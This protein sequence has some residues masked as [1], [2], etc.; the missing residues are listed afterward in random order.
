M[1]I[2]RA[3][4][5]LALLLA[6]GLGGW[7]IYG[8]FK[9][10]DSAS[11]VIYYTNPQNENEVPYSVTLGPARDPQSV[12]FYAATQALAGPAADVQAVRF[13][14]GTYVRSVHVTGST[15]EVDL[16]GEV[17]RTGG[18]SFAESGAFKGL[19][20]TMTGLPGISAVAVRIE[21]SKVPT[22]PGGHLALDE[23]L[24]R[25]NW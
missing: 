13:P 22:L 25:S 21:G 16:S 2:S 6:A 18:G 20:W 1:S 7:W 12:A 24:T 15:V 17:K 3:L 19:V 14:R 5:L 23:P 10:A 8:H 4:T 9:P 11:I